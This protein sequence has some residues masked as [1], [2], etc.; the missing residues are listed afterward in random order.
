MMVSR[1]AAF[2]ALVV[3]TAKSTIAEPSRIEMMTTSSSG[4]PTNVAIFCLNV[5]CS[6]GV[7]VATDRS[8][9]VMWY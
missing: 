2:V 4:A 3:I 7:K 5:S 1:A 8:A 6:A 9:K